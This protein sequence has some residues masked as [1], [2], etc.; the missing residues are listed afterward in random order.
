MNKNPFSI[1]EILGYVF[2]GAFSLFVL[3]FFYVNVN[4]SISDLTVLPQLLKNAINTLK[5]NNI[6]NLLDTSVILISSYVIGHF[7]A[8]LSS[9]TVER[10]F[11][12]VFGYP[13]EFLL[14]KISG[15]P[16]WKEWSDSQRWKKHCFICLMN[17]LLRSIVFLALLPIS[18]LLF[19][20]FLTRLDA[21]FT[22]P[23][24][25]YLNDIITRK[26]IELEDKLMLPRSSEYGLVDSHR[27]IYHY[28]YEFCDNHRSKM[29]NYVAL[30]GFLRSCTLIFSSIWLFLFVQ[31]IRSINF[32]LQVNWGNILLLF[33]TAI[34]SFIFF[35]GFTK[36]YRRFTLESLM[37][38]IIKS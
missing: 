36:F 12:W 32:E 11:L 7:V 18:L 38:L 28:A 23:L 30:Y 22:K 21:F 25:S 9:I 27:V 4:T 10:L 5:E 1:Y 17:V 15:F 24:D 8:Y 34:I 3:F 29:D 37:C 33:V 14:G 2:P 31:S 19:I 16:F 26:Q 35:L 6:G 13:S 20:L